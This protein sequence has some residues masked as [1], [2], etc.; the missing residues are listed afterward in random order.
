MSEK[1]R[2]KSSRRSGPRKGNV[3]LHNLFNIRNNILEMLGERGYSKYI[4]KYYTDITY[5]E[6]EGIYAKNDIN[7]YA[8]KKD[9]NGVSTQ[10]IIYFVDPNSMV[11]KNKQQFIKL[12]KVI[13]QTYKKD[14]NINLI[15][16]A[17]DSDINPQ[18]SNID[19]YVTSYNKT[20]YEDT[21]HDHHLVAELFYYSEVSMN[22][23]THRLV[24]KHILMTKD[25]IKEMLEE[26]KITK[27][28]LPQIEKNDPISKYY[29]AQI[30]DVFKIYRKSPTTGISPPFYRVV[31]GSS[32]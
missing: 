20:Y 2:D 30:G 21:V 26:K 6:F 7:I 16:I 14:A 18:M 8:Y 5:N 4:K 9:K 23:T 32:K 19:K 22:K 28:Q 13:E 10:C 25:E 1:K 3:F 11:G 12:T 29:G 15:F 27:D 31:I 17:E 24:P